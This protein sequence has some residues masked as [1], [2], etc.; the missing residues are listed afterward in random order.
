MIFFRC[1]MN[2]PDENVIYRVEPANGV[3]QVVDA[4]GGI[5][6]ACRDEA[7]AGQY[8]ALLSQAYHRGYKAGCRKARSNAQSRDAAR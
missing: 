7:N 4:T 1:S 3:F 5:I 2:D 6:L 8:A